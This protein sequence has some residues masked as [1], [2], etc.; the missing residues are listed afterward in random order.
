MEAQRARSL[1]D[2]AAAVLQDALDVLPLHASQGRLVGRILSCTP[3]NA[4]SIWPASAGLVREAAARPSRSRSRSRCFDPQAGDPADRVTPLVR[5]RGAE[6]SD[7]D[8]FYPSRLANEPADGVEDIHT[9]PVPPR[10]AR[11]GVEF[12]F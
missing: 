12:S 5:A 2:G 4:G 1:R 11:I 8:Y 9:H 3:S 6:V 10:S 7:I